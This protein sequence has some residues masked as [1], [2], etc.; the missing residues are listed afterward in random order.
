MKP[1]PPTPEKPHRIIAGVFTRFGGKANGFIKEIIQR[2]PPHGC[3]VEVF[4]GGA[5]LLRAIP[6]SKQRVEVLNDTDA[7][8]VNAFRCVRFHPEALVAELNFRLNSRQEI[9][10]CLAQPGF[11]DLQRAAA[12]LHLNGISFSGDGVSF[13]VSRKENTAKGG[14]M[15]LS[16]LQSRIRELHQRLNGVAIE[17]LDW[18]RCLALYDR[19]NTFFFC[20]P[21]YADCDCKGYAPWTQAQL[22]EL[23]AALQTLQ[24]RWLLTVNDSPANRELFSFEK[25][26]AVSR[27]RGVTAEGQAKAKRYGELIVQDNK[28][29]QHATRNTDGVNRKS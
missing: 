22:A 19:P 23:A 8:V 20:D 18:K 24:G 29:T 4:A 14:Q 28:E 16:G 17:C 6:P 12:W 10:D 11:T 9:R 15:S 26:T 13:G 5:A 25:I 3:Y 1:K 27:A 21:P 7:N 2:V